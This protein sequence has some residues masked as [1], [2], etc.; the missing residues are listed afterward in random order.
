MAVGSEKREIKKKIQFCIRAME[1]TGELA[2]FMS[3]AAN[4]LDKVNPIIDHLCDE[5]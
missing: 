3:E 5:G 2:N 4:I 1:G